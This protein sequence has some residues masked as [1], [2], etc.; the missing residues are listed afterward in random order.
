MRQY[1]R[2]ALVLLEWDRWLQTQPIDP[3]KATAR[4]TLKFFCELEDGRSPLLDF[5]STGRDK[6]QVIHAWLLREG[7]VSDVVSS[8]SSP[9]RAAGVAFKAGVLTNS[10][11]ACSMSALPSTAEIHKDDP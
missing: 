8:R 6:W 3:S 7:R 10:A 4:D 9:R 5:R 11:I 2:K 1:E